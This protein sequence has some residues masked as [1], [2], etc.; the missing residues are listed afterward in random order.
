MTMRTAIVREAGGPDQIAIE[1]APIP[2]PGAGELRVRVA[3]ASLNPLDTHARALR[4]DWMHPGFP[5]TPGYEYAGVVDAVGDGVDEDWIGRR[6]ASNGLW[7]GNAD[8]TVADA[9]RVAV[10]PDGFDWHTATTYSTCAYTSWLLI[11]SAGKVQPGQVVVLHSAA[12]AV[13]ILCTQVAKDAGAT[14]IALAGGQEKLSYI[15]PFGAD[16]RIDYLRD[17]WP[18]QVMEA[19]DGR[20]AD[21]IIDGNQGPNALRNFECIAPLGNVIF[22]GASA[23]LAAEINISMLIGKSCSATGFVQYFHQAVSGGRERE[24]MHAALASGKFRIPV[25]KIYP[26]ED[27]A[28]A[29]RAWEHREL[30][31]RTLIEL[32]GEL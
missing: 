19:T 26:L 25:E 18:G 9:N 20:G 30:M 5:F 15:E 7:G 24:E 11:H 3:Y 21:L 8:Y 6:V 31:G 12:G 16:H 32:G 2:E 13:G 10:V 4:V 17:D 1:E 14:V 29:H 22:I 27:L 28:E 23:G